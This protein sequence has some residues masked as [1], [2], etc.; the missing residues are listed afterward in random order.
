MSKN[1]SL[2]VD[3]LLAL[4][5]GNMTVAHSRWSQIQQTPDLKQWAENFQPIAQERG[6]L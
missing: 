5:H 4:D 2:I 3:L 1:I 6:L